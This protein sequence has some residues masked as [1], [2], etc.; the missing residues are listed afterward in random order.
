[1]AIEVKKIF[2]HNVFNKYLQIKTLFK[3]I[4]IP[5]LFTTSSEW[6]GKI[7]QHQPF[8]LRSGSMCHR[9]LSWNTWYACW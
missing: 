8:V 1:L 7:C 6:E 5:A 4:K 2:I 9:K 3:Y